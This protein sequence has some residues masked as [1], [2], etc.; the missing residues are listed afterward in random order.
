[1][2]RVESIAKLVS[3]SLDELTAVLESSANAKLLY[4]FINADNQFRAGADSD[5]V[6]KKTASKWKTESTKKSLTHK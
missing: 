3:L 1:M 2:N 4:D 6:D 5:A